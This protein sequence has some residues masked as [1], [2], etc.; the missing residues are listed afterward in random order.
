MS[1]TK[2]QIQIKRN[3]A[4]IKNVHLSFD[5]GT[6]DGNE[7]HKLLQQFVEEGGDVGHSCYVV[8]FKILN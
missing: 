2:T 3:E 7:K 6:N 8:H 5:E 1:I 4:V